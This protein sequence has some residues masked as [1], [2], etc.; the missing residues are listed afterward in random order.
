MDTLDTGTGEIVTSPI[1]RSPTIGK[2]TAAL[3]KAQAKLENVDKTGRG[4]F[5]RYAELSAVVDQV[6]PVLAGEHVATYQAVTSSG[7]SIQITTLLALGD[8]YLESDT[9]LTVAKDAV[10]EQ[11]GGFTYGRR[12]ALLAALGL[13]P[14]DDEGKVAQGDDRPVQAAQAPPKAPRGKGAKITAAQ[15]SRIFTI[16]KKVGQDLDALRVYFES[17]GW[18]STKDMPQSAFE[19]VCERIEAGT[20]PAPEPPS[21]GMS[22]AQEIGDAVFPD[23]QK[24][25]R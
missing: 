16:A 17:R 3:A 24:G 20:I 15:A 8:E 22:S 6:R 4:N 14:E 19:E 18:P 11:C 25:A 2:L 10:W 21:H 12:Y 9:V 5:G 13:A 7:R 1:R 23:L